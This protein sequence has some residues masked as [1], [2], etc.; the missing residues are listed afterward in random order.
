MN[1]LQAIFLGAIEGITEFL[2]ISS[3]G[4]LIVVSQILKI[5][6]S[7]FV[8]TFEIAIQSGAILSVALIYWQVLLKKREYLKKVIVAFVP[9]AIVGFIGYK[10][11]KTFLLGNVLVTLGALFI[12]GVVLLV[13][14]K[15]FKVKKD[16]NIDNLSYKNSFWIGVFQSLAMIP[17]VSRSAA[18]MLP[19]ML[20]GMSRQ[21]A[22]EFS[23]M[24]AIP[25]MGA[26][27]GYDL[28]KSLHNFSFDN[29]AILLVGFVAS[30]V[31]AYFAVKWFLD[32]IKK[33]SLAVFGVYRIVIAVLGF[34]SLKLFL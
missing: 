14:E 33:N 17:G 9:T 18:T 29:L 22:G 7:D 34:A 20:L 31:T 24:L 26:A 23:F 6:Q 25:T 30:F 3:T 13:F 1:I 19:A 2:P 8:K 5:A 21:S 10:I 27:T 11:I 32:Y 28:L 15:F 12:G 16:G 4:H